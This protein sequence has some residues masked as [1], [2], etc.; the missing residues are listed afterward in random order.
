MPLLGTASLLT[1]ESST[2]LVLS[3][4]FDAGTSDGLVAALDAAIVA[5]GDL[6]V[7]MTG[8]LFLDSYAL[9]QV[10]RAARVLSGEGRTLRIANPPRIVTRLLHAAGATDLLQP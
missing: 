10:E 8:V 7:D 3:G 6:V 2:T 1:F 9:R 5:S 4:E